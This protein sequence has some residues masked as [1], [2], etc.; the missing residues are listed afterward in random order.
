MDDDD[1]DERDDDPAAEKPDEEE[2]LDVTNVPVWIRSY[3]SL[4][5]AYRNLPVVGST[6]DSRVG[7]VSLSILWW[8]GRFRAV[9]LSSGDDRPAALLPLPPPL[10]SVL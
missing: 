9:V 6:K 3:K 8:R 2:A 7:T 4:S 1:D 5:S 10:G